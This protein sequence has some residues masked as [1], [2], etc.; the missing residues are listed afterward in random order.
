MTF[1]LDENILSAQDLREAIL[2]IK[3][4]ASWFGHNSVKKRL[5][6]KS[7]TEPVELTPAAAVLLRQGLDGQ[8]LTAARLD[9]V[10][11]ALEDFEAETEQIT[12]TLAALP[13]NNL[14]KI[15]ANWCRANLKPDLLV[16]FQFNSTMLG[17]LVVNY[18]SHIHDWSFRRRILEESHRFPEVL[19]NV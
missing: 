8:T 16:N 15:L 6:A 10:I 3:H 18:G 19:R 13:G 14:K 4:Y 7:K 9:K 12:I 17:G 5:G 2:E 11:G 1:K